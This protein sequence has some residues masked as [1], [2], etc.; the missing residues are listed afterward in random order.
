MIKLFSHCLKMAAKSALF[1]NEENEDVRR[2]NIVCSTAV[3]RGYEKTSVFFIHPLFNSKTTW[4]T[5]TDICCYHDTDTFEGIPIPMPIDYDERTRTYTCGVG[6]FCDGA[7]VA[8]YMNEHP[9]HNNALCL[10]WL[11]Q[12]MADVFGVY[13]DFGQ[14]PPQCSLKKFGGPLDID[15]FRALSKC[16]KAVLMYTPRFMVC[17]LAFELYDERRALAETEDVILTQEAASKHVKRIK[18]RLKNEEKSATPSTPKQMPAPLGPVIVPNAMATDITSV[19]QPPIAKVSDTKT[20]D[21]NVDE[22]LKDV[23]LIKAD[24]AKRWEIRDL[25]RPED[26][27]QVPKQHNYK[28][29]ALSLYEEFVN[30]K[31]LDDKVD[32][33]GD[34]PK[35]KPG[36]K[37]KATETTTK[38]KNS[39]L[40]AA[41]TADPPA[42]AAAA[43]ANKSK[44]GKDNTRGSLDFFLS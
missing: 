24:M 26:A 11:K 35:K 12:M 8:A 4:P 31:K 44:K 38:K 33:L 34:G 6:I 42:V 5:S 2:V 14:A 25:K 37:P 3:R 13:D 41:S 39:K 36:K 9:R 19:P 22:L 20:D 29:G 27:V 7:C 43:P 40:D 21:V 15:A 28:S 17:N 32:A 16:K 30:G 18:K 23:D 10:M 1:F